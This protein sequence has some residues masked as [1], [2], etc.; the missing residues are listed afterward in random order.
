M[1]CT[2]SRSS[3][4]ASVPGQRRLMEWELDEG[5]HAICA[6]LTISHLTDAQHIYPTTSLFYFPPSLS[7][8]SSWPPS[9]CNTPSQ[10]HQ[11][12]SHTHVLFS[13]PVCPYVLTITCIPRC[14]TS[15]RTPVIV[16]FPN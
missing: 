3:L 8:L 13:K 14:K 5:E 10:A 11:S 6:A 4:M 16:R 1:K 7:L 9:I 2:L 12:T 15:G